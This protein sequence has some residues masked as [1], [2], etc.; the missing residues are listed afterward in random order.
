MRI[1]L[2][3]TAGT[4]LCALAIVGVHR[5]F[6]QEK[7]PPFAPGEKL[8]Y[9]VLWSIFPAGE[10]SAT[11]RSADKGPEDTYEVVTTARSQGFVSLLYSV[12]N[13]FHSLFDPRSAC[14]RSISKKINEGRRHKQTRIVFDSPRKLAILDERD[15]SRPHDPPKHAENEIPA[16]V[17]DVVTGFYFLRRQDFQVGKP[18]Q[19]PVND[20]AKT[21]DVTV[22]VQAH[23]PIQTPLGS[24]EAFRVEPKVFGSLFKRKGRMLIWFSDDEQ[25]LPLRIK[26]LVSIGSLTG[27]LRS[28]SQETAASSGRP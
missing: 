28:V 26:F 15:L 25:H 19:L 23:E 2:L 11:L 14:S 4:L 7:E 27:T 12:Q 6:T 16:C 1:P 10:V 20:G 17:E 18:I 9:D 5:G 3:R 21:Y 8:T 13:E 22:E 24:R